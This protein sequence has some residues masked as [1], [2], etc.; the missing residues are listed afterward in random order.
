MRDQQA[1]GEPKAHAS[2]HVASLIRAEIESGRL[3]AGAKLPS[4]RRLA[5]E[6]GVAHNTAQAAVRLLQSEGWVTIR[7]ASGAYVRDRTVEPLNTPDQLQVGLTEVRDQLRETRRSLTA[8]EEAV[9]GL[10]DRL[11]AD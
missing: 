8:A 3:P 4:Y 9:E 6:H 2:R 7:A 5:D 10:L 11:K 1:S